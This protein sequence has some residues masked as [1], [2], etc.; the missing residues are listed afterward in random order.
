MKRI[1]AIVPN[2]VDEAGVS[3]RINQSFAD[4]VHS[5]RRSQI[6]AAAANARL[7]D[8]P[9]HGAD[10]RILVSRLNE[11]ANFDGDMTLFKN[12]HSGGIEVGRF[13]EVQVQ[14]SGDTVLA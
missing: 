11:K 9:L 14:I 1:N 2:P 10:E 12:R 5:G 7:A 6:A 3:A 13:Q 4:P 8:G